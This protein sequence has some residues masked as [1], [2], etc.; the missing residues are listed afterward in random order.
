MQ[1]YFGRFYFGELKPYNSKYCSNFVLFWPAVDIRAPLILR[2]C[3]VRDIREIKGT[4]TL[5]VL[6]YM[7]LFLA[8]VQL[9]PPRQC[10]KRF[11]NLYRISFAELCEC[12]FP[13]CQVTWPYIHRESKKL[14]HPNHGYKFVSSWSIC[15]ILSLLQRAINFQQSPCRFTQHTLSVLLHYLGKHKFCTFCARKT[16]FICYFLS[17]YPAGICQMSWKYVQRLTV[18]KYQHFTFCSF[19]VLSKLKVLQLSKV[20]LSTTKYQH[21]KNLTPWADATWIKKH[22]KMLIVCMS[23]FTKGVQNFH[24]LHRHMPGDAFSTGQ[25]QCR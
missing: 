14:C 9:F 5:R 17:F 4:P 6:Q 13:G 18:C 21:S 22:V 23:L 15:K 19:T 2:F 12:D 1:N 20:G 25:L 10:W 8:S 24:H 11:T 3:L 16:C 7:F